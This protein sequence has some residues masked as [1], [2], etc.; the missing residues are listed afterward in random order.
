VKQYPS[1]HNESHGRK[2]KRNEQN[3]T[4]APVA[5]GWV[6]NRK[7]STQLEINKETVNRYVKR[8]ESDSMNFSGLLR[9]DDPV[10]EHCMSGGSPA[11]TDERFYL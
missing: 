2:N 6:S 10:L 8:A 7:I 3:Q 9:L 1:K 5:S 4:N 11:Y